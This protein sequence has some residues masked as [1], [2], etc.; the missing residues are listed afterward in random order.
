VSEAHRELPV[1]V[2]PGPD[3]A[4]A[5]EGQQLAGRFDFIDRLPVPAMPDEVTNREAARPLLLLA[6]RGLLVLFRFVQLMVRLEI[7]PDA[8]FMPRTRSNWRAVSGSTGALPAM[9]SLISFADR[10]Q[11]RAN[12]ACDISRAS[13]ISA[14]TAPGVTA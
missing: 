4:D 9:I 8:R 12:S 1:P 5:E 13:S 2:L 11:R 6:Q 7:E 3:R 14:S 10:P